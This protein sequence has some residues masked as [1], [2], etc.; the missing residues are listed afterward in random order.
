MAWCWHRAKDTTAKTRRKFSDLVFTR[1]FTAFDRNNTASAS[2]PFHGFFTLFWLGVGIF[3]MQIAAKNYQK[4]GSLFGSNEI[5][6]MSSRDLIVL[7]LSDGVM[8]LSTGFG[9]IL[10]VLIFKNVLSWNREGWIIQSVFELLFIGIGV[11]WTLV[12]HVGWHPLVKFPERR[13]CSWVYISLFNQPRLFQEVL[14][15]GCPDYSK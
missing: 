12:R 3:M 4:Y 11:K 15:S 13:Y 5:M 9:W 6:A 8:F 7:G 10:Q 1:Q 2:S 14:F